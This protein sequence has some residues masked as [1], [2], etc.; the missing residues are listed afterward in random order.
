MILIAMDRAASV[1]SIDANGFL[2]V[3][4]SNISKANVC[5]YMGREIPDSQALGLDPDKVYYLYREPEE[6]ARAAATFNN[7]PLLSEHL[8][9]VPDD[10]PE[11]LIIGS[12]GTDAA[13]E[14]PY[15]RNSL[16]VWCARHQRAIES[17]QQREL[18]CGYRY[19]AD[20]TP[21]TTAD[22]L[23]YDGVMRDII[24]NHVALVVEGR[25]GPDVVVGDTLM[26]LKSRTAL[27]ISGALASHIRPHLSTD[28]DI[29]PALAGVNGKTFALDGAPRQLASRVY[30]LVKPHL[31]GDALTEAMLSGA[32]TAVQPA[33]IAM[34]EGA[35]P[36]D[37]GDK[38]DDDEDVEI[39]VAED[40]AEED[41]KQ[42]EDEGETDADKPAM[43]AATVSRLIAAAEARAEARAARRVVAIEQ[44][45]ADV[46]PLVGEVV[47]MDSAERIYRFAL[48]DAG[49]SAADLKGTPIPTLKAMVGREISARSRPAAAMDSAAVRRANDS[50]EALYGSK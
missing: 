12:T 11:E 36:D 1:R 40:E 15:L 7:V 18:S 23:R 48:E 22:G 16:V 45:R 20:M 28:V 5:P 27:M 25:A 49:Y 10:L 47:G 14:A 24:G 2:H 34:D 35:D 42:A 37:K 43:D 33:A 31:S 50:F 8:P 41:G 21:G 26:Q 13:F 44:A 39:N 17:E 3:D 30:A 29:S 6:L 46:R 19:R 9:V 38:D 4:V 32:L